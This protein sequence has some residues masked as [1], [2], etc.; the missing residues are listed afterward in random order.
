M[1]RFDLALALHRKDF[2]ASRHCRGGKAVGVEILDFS[3]LGPYAGGLEEQADGWS[4][5]LEGFR[6][7]RSMHGA[8]IDLHAGAADP[9][10]VEVN[11]LRHR[12][13]LRAARLAGCDVMTVHS[14]F[15]PRLPE[16][17]TREHLN[18]RMAGYLQWLADQAGEHGVRLAIENV[19]EADPRLISDLCEGIGRSNVGVCL[20]V[21]HA[22]LSSGYGLDTWVHE[23]AP[24]LVSMH[25]HDNDRV[26]D[27][28]WGIGLGTVPFNA[29]KRA[30]ADPALGEVRLTVEAFPLEDA[31]ESVQLVADATV[32]GPNGTDE[33][34]E[35]SK[36]AQPA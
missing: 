17:G 30:L 24:L 9:A 19:F 13:S 12:Q 31:W 27:R 3:D 14:G 10:V 1:T 28:H 15:P 33:C 25:L 18:R 35:R 26:H 7:A 5:A 8:Y 36:R 34:S 21:G 22:Y 32:A 16:P 6:G 4:R 23:L 2:D 29:L 11:R 20:D